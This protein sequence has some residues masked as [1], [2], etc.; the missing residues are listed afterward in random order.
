MPDPIST[1]APASKEYDSLVSLAQ[2]VLEFRILGPMDVVGDGGSVNLGGPQQR[3]I[4]ALL[5][6]EPGTV[7]TFD[8]MVDALWPAGDSP[9]NARRSA[10]TYVS[11][12]RSVLGDG[13]VHTSDVGYTIDSAQVN[14][15]ADRFVA[16]VERARS[17]PPDRA[18]EILG[19]A[20]AL[21]RGPVFGD[22]HEEW[23]ARP[24]AGKLDELRLTA[25][26]ERV[27][28]MSANGWDGR[29]VAEASSLVDRYPLREQF[30]EQA[31]RG[32]HA[33][34]QTADALRVFQRHRTELGE[35]TG[36]DP[37]SALVSLERS[38][39]QGDVVEPAS[40]LAVR[41]L[42]GYVL[43]D[44]L[45]EG[46][47]GVVYRATQPGIGREVAIKVI[48]PELADDRSFVHRFEKEA[49][50][51]ARLEH[52]H[53]VP[54]YDFWRQPGAAFLVFRLL[55]GGSAAD[56]LRRSG[57]FALTDVSRLLDQ[58]G[59]ALS[60]AHAANV[61]HRDVKPSN[62]L[63]DGNEHAY[64]A[65]FG[66]AASVGDVAT[67]SQDRWSAGSLLYA[68]PE[69]L[70]DGIEDTKA[71]QY[72]LAATIWELLVGRPP[73]DEANS[74]TLIARKLRAP[75]AGIDLV[76]ADIPLEAATVLSRAGSVHPDDRYADIAEFVGAWHSALLTA[77]T[78][79]TDPSGA[80]GRP[81]IAGPQ[82]SATLPASFAGLQTNPFRGLRP[83]REVDAD[84]FFGRQALAE[85]L[86]DE[87]TSTSF[88]A[89]VGPS[90]SGKSSLVLAGLVP[91][92]RSSGALIAI[93]TPGSRPVEAL[94][95][96]LSSIARDEHRHLLTP[97]V[98]RE[99]HGIRAAVLAV[100]SGDP[101]VV[102]IDQCEELWTLTAQA[103]RDLL[104]N[105]L[106]ELVE[107]R[108]IQ[109]VVTIRADF[110]DRPLA[111]SMLGS[112]VAQHVFGVTPL[113]AAE[114][115][116]A[117]TRP[118]EHVGVRFE[119]ALVSRLVA[120]AL[121]QPGTLPLLQFVLAEL[122]ERRSGASI[123]VAAY[124]DL[125]G[126]EGSISSQADE[127]VDGLAGT[128]RD[129]VRRLFAR[130]VSPGEGEF[131]DDF[132]SAATDSSFGLMAG[133]AIRI[134]L[135][136]PASAYSIA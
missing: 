37:S 6:A 131:L 70:R 54:L 18:A 73:F 121:D 114:L 117:I 135:D 111:D 110:L 126:L 43:H 60:V 56:V 3:R 104:C 7:L 125:G 2:G 32:L 90:G 74:S 129:S 75:I 49:Q 45:G 8:R 93:M 11:R 39:V 92:L 31:M 57:P 105:G 106:M 52:P 9:P 10:I 136:S 64:L 48:R 28:A 68:S 116:E 30:V 5:L 25:M 82:R 50:L 65:D 69:Q 107:D 99:Q 124:D 120:E 97:S 16:L 1:R 94:G 51:V 27:D 67:G 89:V 35:R 119:P 22:L 19:D 113:T 103:E 130:L 95:L 62:I 87:M 55:A 128:D 58:I 118:A 71:D 81:R 41:S 40:A 29:A 134:P 63:F 123:T 26:A 115:H 102:L 112:W 23:W 24:I 88:V 14:T 15:D 76:R 101:L 34:G 20:L 122:F 12:L 4:L 100:A 96:A 79:I 83:F 46:S 132:D 66:I 44:P 91:R 108:L 61:V 80:D 59:G 78:A 38:L 77:N 33:L 72:C 86:A 36:L 84:T 133:F 85:R 109:V 127:L 21:W 47:F 13:I 98:L 42:R 53:I 17:L